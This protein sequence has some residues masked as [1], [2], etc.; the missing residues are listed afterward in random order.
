MNV[1]EL[2]A[3]RGQL[4]VVSALALTLGA[5]CQAGCQRPAERDWSQKIEDSEQRCIAAS[6]SAMSE[7][8]DALD[9]HVER[10]VREHEAIERRVVDVTCALIQHTRRTRYPVVEFGWLRWFPVCLECKSGKGCNLNPV[11]P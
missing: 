8:N 9:G 4:I 3:G 1:L 11:A 5:T 6:L 10:E 7:I 2:F